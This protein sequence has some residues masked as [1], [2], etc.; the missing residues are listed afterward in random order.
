MQREKGI[1]RRDFLRL[2]MATGAA[3]GLAGSVRRAL[4]IPAASRHGSILDVEYVVI[5]MQE[6]RSFDHYFGCL[7]GV[8]GF[9]DPHPVPLPGGG[10]VWRQPCWSRRSFVDPFRL[11][12]RTCN[13]Q[14]FT[15]LPHSWA[16][17]HAA[18]DLGRMDG[19]IGA[20]GADTM[21]YY[22]RR[23]LPFHY[24]LA[25][26]F[27]V[28]DAYF[29]SIMSAT[30]PN[31][32]F[33]MSGTNDPLGRHGG[34]PIF[35]QPLENAGFLLPEG[36]AFDWTT[37]PER[38][39]EAGVSWRLY[40]GVDDN[41]PF[42]TS[43]QDAISLGPHRTR[44]GSRTVSC[45]NLLRFF[46]QY[47][48]APAGSA[49]AENAMRRRP[50]S[51]FRA[52]A[53]AGRLPSVSWVF[54]PLYHS[55]H[56]NWAPAYG[57]MFIAYVLDALTANP[58]TWRKTALLIMYDENDGYFDHVPP[59]TPPVDAARGASNVDTR[60]EINPADGMP[61]GLGFRVPLLVVSPWSKGGA[62]CSQ[63]FDHTSVIRFLEARFGVVEPNISAWRRAVCGDL[64]SA[65][66]FGLRDEAV[67]GLPDTS[68]YWQ[69]VARQERLPAPEP[70]A[71]KMSAPLQEEGTRPA[72][73]L[74]YRLECGMQLRSARGTAEI[75][76]LNAG[77][78]GAVF[79]V[80]DKRAQAGPRNFTVR[81]NSI[82]TAGIQVP[83]SG[84][85]GLEV[86]GPGGFF[87]EFTA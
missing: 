24:A 25:D 83:G 76:F 58:E 27:T 57:A 49:L 60:D 67:G 74:P 80:F 7:G 50:P 2:A 65:F 77:S 11:D 8:R 37:Y 51:Q 82:L 31:R 54:P 68:E 19:W 87:R 63:V 30:N 70:A 20:K 12:G 75:R 42:V 53:R 72:R 66:D 32:T 5:L 9:D 18:W 84:P 85:L 44:D 71:G 16:D 47:F 40:Q 10:S 4:A 56:P 13:A 21:G 86:H 35:A 59:P 22:T 45:F 41:G 6:N 34:G 28:C 26:A 64:T 38:L 48:Y 15:S 79:H 73:P 39:Q 61:N 33:L 52:D 55:E 14:G 17:G 69:L 62:V 29:C 46:K 3:G 43:P 36:P 1:R 81:S 23:E 78:A